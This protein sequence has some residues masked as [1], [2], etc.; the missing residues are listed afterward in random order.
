M[1]AFASECGYRVD[2]WADAEKKVKAATVLIGKEVDAEHLPDA[3]AAANMETG[4]RPAE[5]SVGGSEAKK[6]RKAQTCKQ[7]GQPKKGHECPNK[8]PKA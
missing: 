3:P 4:K 8:K 7:C 5:S 6:P 2:R 1:R